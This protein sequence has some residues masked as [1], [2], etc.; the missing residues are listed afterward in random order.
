MRRQSKK[1][2]GSFKINMMGREHNRDLSQGTFED[3]D[4]DLNSE[5]DYIDDTAE[6]Y[7]KRARYNK[8]LRAPVAPA[9]E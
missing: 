7:Q 4:E 6:V 9:K 8:S 5:G 1:S 2:N 3:I